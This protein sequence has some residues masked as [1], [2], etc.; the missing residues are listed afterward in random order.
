MNWCREWGEV[1]HRI[2]TQASCTRFSKT[3]HDPPSF[4]PA[5]SCPRVADLVELGVGLFNSAATAEGGGRL[6]FL[7][8]KNNHYRP[9]AVR[10]IF[11]RSESA[12]RWNCTSANIDRQIRSRAHDW[13][14]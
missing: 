8:G 10:E 9:G 14:P 11:G 13:L 4:P 5:T 6:L 7:K 12:A 1:G 2:E 3:R